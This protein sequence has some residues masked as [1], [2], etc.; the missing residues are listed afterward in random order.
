MCENN[1]CHPLSST[2]FHQTFS[3]WCFF[4]IMKPRCLSGESRFTY[5]KKKRATSIEVGLEIIRRD[6]SAKH[7][8][9]VNV[10]TRWHMG[11]SKNGGT[12]K[13]S[14]LIGFSIIN[15]PFWGTLIFG[16]THM[17]NHSNDS[18]S[19]LDFDFFSK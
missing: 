6:F 17:N 18:E 4:H 10:L 2:K 12:T 15:H 8:V 11:V 3:V 14:I 9:G 7:P 13:S 16:N 1:F 19:Q 5:P